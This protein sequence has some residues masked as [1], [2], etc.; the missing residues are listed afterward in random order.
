MSDE[1]Q[2]MVAR[3]HEAPPFPWNQLKHIFCLGGDYSSDTTAKQVP[4]SVHR[5][6]DGVRFASLERA[7]Y[8]PVMTAV[9]RAF[10]ESRKRHNLQP[11][12]WPLLLA[13]E[14][15]LVYKPDRRGI[16]RLVAYRP[17][18][19]D[20][21]MPDEEAARTFNL[22]VSTVREYHRKTCAA[23]EDEWQNLWSYE[24]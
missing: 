14:I 9:A 18:R 8:G 15:G 19:A 6:F 5:L 13:V 24:G 7:Q 23:I 21:V 2:M 1:T 22:A 11:V 20:A 3:S 17:E 16:A 10:N 4:M 12:C